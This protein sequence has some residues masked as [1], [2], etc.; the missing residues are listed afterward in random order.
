MIDGA[1]FLKWCEIFQV[2]RGS[3]GG[4]VDL[5][6]AYDN[7]A[8]A[9]INLTSNRPVK[10]LNSSPPSTPANSIATA[11][12]GSNIVANNRI[13]GWTFIPSIDMTVTALQYDVALYPGGATRETGIYLRTT[14][15]LLGS[16]FISNSDPIDGS[17]HYYTHTLS[18]KINLVAG[19]E[20]VFATVVPINNANHNNNDAVPDSNISVTEWDV[21]TA[22]SSPLPLA[23]PTTFHALANLVQVG[24]FQYVTDTQLETVSI[25]DESTSDR[26]MEVSSTFS[27]RP[28]FSA[29]RDEANLFPDY[30]VYVSSTKNLQSIPT[31]PWF[32]FFEAFD[33]SSTNAQF[34]AIACEVLDDTAGAVAGRMLFGAAVPADAQVIPFFAAN[35]QSGHCENYYDLD[36]INRTAVS[37]QTIINHN[38]V[39]NNSSATL[40]TYVCLNA[41]L[42]DNT[43]SAEDGLLNIQVMQSG[44]LTTYI[45]LLGGASTIGINKPSIY[46]GVLNIN[47]QNIVNV[48]NLTTASSPD[49]SAQLQLTSTSKAFLPNTMT[50]VQFAGIISPATG[51]LAYDTNKLRYTSWNGSAVKDIA[52]TTDIT[53]QSGTYVPTFSGASGGN[54]FTLVKALYSTNSTASGNV[55]NVS[56]Q[57]T[58]TAS[59]GSAAISISLPVN[60]TFS[61]TGQA[62]ISGGE[63]YAGVPAIGDGML[64]NVDTIATQSTVTATWIVAT[65]SG[66]KTVN[67][68]FAYQIQ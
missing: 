9:E 45:Q 28:A 6:D 64:I 17:G 31:Q 7:G 47:S 42:S 54:T 1:D 55:V 56:M 16:A 4:S 61:S 65:S 32:H 13:L 26:V 63:V 60:T 53:G 50:T 57:F 19:T 41:Y 34:G 58:Y 59:A 23:F 44:T 12:T 62:A 68:S 35:G 49:P 18:S 51:L 29:G 3:P 27:S 52:Y 37:S 25:N 15:E 30:G 11:S 21:G 67:L 36:S 38:F 46:S 24:S 22:T 66:S 40:K 33:N 20:Y 48:A 10:F 14:G 2:N 43:A 8:N 39:A 5:Q